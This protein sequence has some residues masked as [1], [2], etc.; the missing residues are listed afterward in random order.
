MSASAGRPGDA[1]VG[2]VGGQGQP[3]LDAVDIDTDDPAIHARSVVLPPTPSRKIG[4][5]GETLFYH[6]PEIEQSQSWNI[7]GKRIVDLIGPGRQTVL[8]PTIH[9]DTGRPITGPAPRASRTWRRTS[10]RRC[11][12]H[13]RSDHGGADAVRLS[14]GAAAARGRR[15]EPTA[16][17]DSSTTS[18]SPIS[19]PG[20]R[21]SA[22]TAAG[23]HAAATRRCQSGGHRRPGREPEERHLNLKIVAKR[24]PGFRCRPGLHAARPG[25]GGMWLRSRYRVPV[26]Q[27]A[28]G[29]GAGIR[30]IG[31]ATAVRERLSRS[32][33]Q[34]SRSNPP[35]RRPTS[36]SASPPFRAP[37]AKSSIGSSRPAGGRT[38]CSRSAPQS[39]SSA[40]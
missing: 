27:R 12:R 40:R 33:K 37:S 28:P 17:I 22:S 29:L 34:L 9:P 2:V 7:G 1:G 19:M 35:R 14:A 23:R 3:R 20:C 26:S 32:H 15:R 25:H 31:A 38:G 36:S 21:R 4:P 10:C 6:G 8:P 11:G 5:R 18:R 16:R 30:S 39:P 24:H 13:R